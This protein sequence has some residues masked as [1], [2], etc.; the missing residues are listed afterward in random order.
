[1]IVYGIPGQTYQLL[2]GTVTADLD[3]GVIE[4]D[5]KQLREL[6]DADCSISQ[7]GPSLGAVTGDVVLVC[8]PG[9]E[10]GPIS[11]GPVGYEAWHDHDLKLWL[12]RVPAAAAVHFCRGAGFYAPDFV[13]DRRPP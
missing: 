12:V 5:G 13:Q 9:A 3:T 1:M 4:T 11:H 2:S 7:T 10:N 6:L 8:P